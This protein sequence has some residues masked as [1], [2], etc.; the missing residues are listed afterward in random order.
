MKSKGGEGEA[1]VGVV[2]DVLRQ[3]SGSPY[4][5]LTALFW[6]AA[7]AGLVVLLRR[8][9]RVALYG[10]TLI[11]VQWAALV[12]VVRPVGIHQPHVLARYVLVALPVVLLWVAGGLDALAEEVSTR[13]GRLPGR[14]V[15]VAAVALL[16]AGSSI[17]ADPWLRLGPF[18]GVDAAVDVGSARRALPPERL[19]AAYRLLAA[20]PGRGA[21]VEAVTT[22]VPNHLDGTLAVA[23]HHRR[24]VVLAV[25]QPWVTAPRVALRTV[26]PAEA[27]RLCRSDAR[28]VVLHRHWLE[29]ESA[30]DELRGVRQLPMGPG[31]R[32]PVPA[33]LR[34]AVEMARECGEPYLAGEERWL[35]DLARRRAVTSGR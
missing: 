8:R 20:E 26:L 25:D 4:P 23:R 14:L 16:A 3:E 7:L 9:P 27:G 29:L 33:T 10:L 21:V 17:A 35:W 13:V 5:E 12:G 22:T 31:P 34:L 1:T 6:I 19:P 18:A 28:F 2:A 15:P 24:P 30:V 11:A 32:K